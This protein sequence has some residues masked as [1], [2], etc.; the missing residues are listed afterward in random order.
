M[1]MERV[2]WLDERIRAGGRPASADLASHFRVS[3]RTAQRDIEFLRDRLQ[4]PLKFDAAARGYVYGD[5]EFYLPQ[6]F[7]RKDEVIALLFARRLFRRIKPPLRDEAADVCGRLDELF[8]A[9]ALSN[10][11]EAVSFEAGR[12]GDA[13]DKVFFDLLRAITRRRAALLHF[14]SRQEGEPAGGEVE[15]LKLHYYRGEWH[16]I[17][18]SPR[19]KKAFRHPLSRIRR[20]EVTGR[21]F[22]P[23]KG[24]IDAD[25]AVRKGLRGGK[26]RN[27]RIRFARG[28]AAW[29]SA[30][31][32]RP[33]RR[34]Q[35]E[36]S[37]AV[38]LEL[39]EAR[40]LEVLG[41]VLMHG[42]EAEVTAPKELRDAVRAEID[43][44]SSEYR[45]R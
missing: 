12:G 18:I 30:Q 45:G 35:P 19:Q 24:R 23:P 26:V 1:T 41:L 36:L 15:P 20:V 2:M 44:L 38:V 3:L 34:L 9:T 37:G 43:R 25:A 8:K 21:H 27:A 14:D 32:W 4:A 6:A 28:K 16:L 33:G 17:G 39:P 5:P 11:E 31:A 7:F 10:A 29:V 13:P 42:E 40:V 22:T